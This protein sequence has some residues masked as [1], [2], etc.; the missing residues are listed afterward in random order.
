MNFSRIKQSIISNSISISFG[1][2]IIMMLIQAILSIWRF[3][4]VKVEFEQVVDVYNVRMELVQKMRVISRE[5]AP[6]LF[7]MINTEDAFEL[8]SLLMEFQQL[9]SRFLVAR[10]QLL[11]TNLSDKETQLLEVH[12][13]YA[14]SVVP[15]QRKVIRLI[16]EGR[17]VEAR[18]LLVDKV[19]PNQV[20]AL[21]HLDEIIAYESESSK[22][23]M[24][25]ARTLFENTQR[26]LGLTTTFGSLI[27]III[28]IIVS[29]RFTY[30]VRTLKKNKEDLED[31]VIERTR[32]RAAGLEQKI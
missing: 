16:Q 26:D 17:T 29:I 25:N 15:D 2:I 7:T 23:A 30:Y 10:K 8:D 27:S 4:E 24:T 20:E 19:S 14:R 5:R 11:E 21:K 3:N 18:K 31:T 12:R 1:V 32:E 6:I 22:Q 9:G 13:E 28:G